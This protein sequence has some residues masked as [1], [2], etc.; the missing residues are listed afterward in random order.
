MTL[1]T[2]KPRELYFQKDVTQD[3]VATLTKEILEINTN[4]QFLRGQYGLYGISYQPA[5]IRLY[6]DSYGGSV[7][8]CLGLL[9]VMK[10]SRVPIHTYVTG[11]AMSAGFMIAISGH[12]RYAYPHSTFMY[13]QLSAC[14]WGKMKDLEENIEEFRRLQKL[15][16]TLTV[17]ATRIPA[18]VLQDNF[19]R[20]KDWFMTVDEA[21]NLG[22]V[23][24]IL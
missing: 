4:D 3:T 24:E 16:Q 15:L 8:Q 21:F 17:Q 23:D 20:K 12:R 13:H 2:P 10:T 6:I 22:C 18:S 14:A 11:V 5:P 1:D 9:G 19:D 7:Y